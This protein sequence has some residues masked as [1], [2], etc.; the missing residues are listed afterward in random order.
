MPASWIAWWPDALRWIGGE[1]YLAAAL[2]CLAPFLWAARGGIA[3]W[4]WATLAG[5]VA[6]FLAAA[7]AHYQGEA[8]AIL[9]GGKTYGGPGKTYPEIASLEAGSLVSL[10][11]SREGWFKIRYLDSRLQ[12]SVGWIEQSAVLKLG[13]GP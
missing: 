7:L 12:E 13:K 1:A 5:A 4:H 3:G 6:F 11:E 9:T 10:E 8:G 2:L